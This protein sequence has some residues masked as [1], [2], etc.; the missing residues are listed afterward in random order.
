MVDRPRP[1]SYI[2]ATC[3]PDPQALATLRHSQRHERRRRAAAAS[4]ATGRGRS[5]RQAV[6][7][8]PPGARRCAPGSF[9]PLHKS[10]LFIFD[11]PANLTVDSRSADLSGTAPRESKRDRDERASA[12]T[13][14]FGAMAPD[15][16]RRDAGILTPVQRPNLLHR[17][18]LQRRVIGVSSADEA[19]SGRHSFLFV[20][21]YS[22]ILR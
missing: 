17:Y 22:A 7:P 3:Q 11:G 20:I 5:A 1:L 9:P 15:R 13:S 10:P 6:D 8:L 19:V 2:G 21:S 4:R 12:V 16:L 14:S 18:F